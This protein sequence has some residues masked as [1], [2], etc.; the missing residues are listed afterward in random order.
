S[1]M[2]AK[3]LAEL[4]DEK[5]ISP[6]SP[7]MF[8]SMTWV[9]ESSSTFAEAPGYTA[10][11]STEGGATVGYIDTGRLKIESAPASMMMIAMTH[12]KTGRSMKKRA[13]GIPY[14]WS[15]GSAES[16]EGAAAWS[17]VAGASAGASAGSPPGA[18]AESPPASTTCTGMPGW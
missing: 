15:D 10:R 8:C 1:E 5:Y 4:L 13:M 9:T 14:C 2:V 16:S 17:A 6:S 3:P 7:V 12:A 11:I 18:E